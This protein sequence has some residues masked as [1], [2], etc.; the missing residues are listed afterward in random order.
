MTGEVRVQI[1]RCENCNREYLPAH[2]WQ[3]WCGAWCR[4]EYRNAELRA[5]RELWRREGTKEIFEEVKAH[6]V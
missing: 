4:V 2:P 6:H 1:R 5:A 3:R